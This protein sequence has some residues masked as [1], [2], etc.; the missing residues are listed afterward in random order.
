MGHK[1]IHH[2]ESKEHFQGLEKELVEL[3]QVKDE[4]N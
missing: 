2:W 1:K 3:K 4:G